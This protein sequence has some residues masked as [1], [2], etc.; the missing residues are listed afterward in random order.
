MRGACV[1]V[2]GWLNRAIGRADAVQHSS[3][4]MCTVEGYV[5]WCAH[6]TAKGILCICAPTARQQKRQEKSEKF[7][8]MESEKLV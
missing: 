7:H 8:L 2:G 5:L 3:M 4:Y 6:A 1:G